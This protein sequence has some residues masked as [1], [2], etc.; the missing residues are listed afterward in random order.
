MCGQCVLFPVN[1][2]VFGIMTAVAF[3]TN[4]IWRYMKNISKVSL[5]AHNLK[6]CESKI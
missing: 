2:M 1:L 5:Y 4:L 3:Y 6:L